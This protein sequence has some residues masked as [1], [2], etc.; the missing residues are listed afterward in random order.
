M[1]FSDKDMF[2]WREVERGEITCTSKDGAAKSFGTRPADGVEGGLG[3]W[4]TSSLGKVFLVPG[5]GG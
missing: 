3:K 2:G 1:K 4:C 5:E